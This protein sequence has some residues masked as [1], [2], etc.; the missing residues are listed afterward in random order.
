MDLQVQLHEIKSTVEIQEQ[1][2]EIQS[3]IQVQVHEIKQFIELQNNLQYVISAKIKTNANVAIYSK[4]LSFR[5]E[6]SDI[7]A[8]YWC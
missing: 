5:Q 7:F 8:V 3:T 6:N 1:L 4:T 2:H